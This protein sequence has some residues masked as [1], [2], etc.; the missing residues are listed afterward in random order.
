VGRDLSVLSTVVG[1]R[2]HVDREG[3]TRHEAPDL[4]GSP[5]AQ[6]GALPARKEGGHPPALTA[7][8]DVPDGV[9][10]AEHRAQ[11]ACIEGTNDRA[12]AD[13]GGEQLLPAHD[14]VLAIRKPTDHLIAVIGA[15]DTHM[16]QKA[17]SDAN[18]PPRCLAGPAASAPGTYPDCT[19]AAAASAA[20]SC[21]RTRSRPLAQNDGS[22]R[23]RPAI[24]ARSSGLREPPAASSSR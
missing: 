9:D 21:S 2:C 19:S 7:Q 15:F 23:S 22:A 18:S 3:R 17:P 10:A 1:G 6:R 4:C 24:A 20:S 14:S 11:T 16:V 12:P 13:A 8:R 5:M